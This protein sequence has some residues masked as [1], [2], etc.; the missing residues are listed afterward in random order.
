MSTNMIK[1]KKHKNDNPDYL[2][3]LRDFDFEE[4][5]PK[6][7]FEDQIK[8]YKQFDYSKN[9]QCSFLP[10]Y[11]KM[12]GTYKNE[13]MKLKNYVF[14]SLLRKKSLNNSIMNGLQVA[15]FFSQIIKQLN[16]TNVINYDNLE[17]SFHNTAKENLKNIKS[18][19]E[20]KLKILK[21]DELANG[22]K[23]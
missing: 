19:F 12:D 8:G 20:N 13:L 14:T 21:N 4:K 9:R 10:F 3:I 7:Y 2:W 11:N 1:N 23:N 17:S 6:A 16:E 5:D 22:I 15:E 18:K